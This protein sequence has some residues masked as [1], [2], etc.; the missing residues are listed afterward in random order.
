MNSAKFR[1]NRK[2]K[3]H[4]LR[5]K[6]KRSDL[7]RSEDEEFLELLEQYK[8]VSNLSFVC[9]YAS[10]KRIM[11][12]H[13]CVRPCVS[14]FVLFIH[15]IDLTKFREWFPLSWGPRC[16]LFNPKFPLYLSPGCLLSSTLHSSIETG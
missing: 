1:H 7:R 16:F 2:R 15:P 11:A 13:L 10:E 5:S 6:L 4:A 3:R 9:T 8:Y 14:M 12:R